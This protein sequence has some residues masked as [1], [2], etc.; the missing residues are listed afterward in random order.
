MTK[1]TIQLSEATQLRVRKVSN[2]DGEELIDLRVYYK[3]KKMDD[4]APTAKGFRVRVEDAK[5]LRDKLN[6]AIKALGD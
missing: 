1:K 6:R 3:T 2:D 5:T 4:Y